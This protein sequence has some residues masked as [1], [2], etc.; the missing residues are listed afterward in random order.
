MQRTRDSRSGVSLLELAIVI[1]IIGMLVGGYV[2]AR[3]AIRQA[4]IRATLTQVETIHSAIKLFNQKFSG[5]PGDLYNATNFWGGTANGD[6]DGRIGSMNSATCAE[7]NAGEWFRAWQHLSSAGLIKGTFS[8]TAGGGGAAEAVIAANVPAA[9][10]RS[11]G[12]TLGVV[13]CPSGSTRF[14]PTQVAH[15]LRFG[16]FRAG[17]PTV[18]GAIGPDEAKQM[19]AK[20][21]DGLPGLGSV[22]GRIPGS[23][24]N[25][26]CTDNA[27]P[28]TAR[29]S[30]TLTTYECSLLFKVGAE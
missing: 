24:E 28:V 14:Y 25:P 3:S 1:I 5:L 15:Y 23:S 18:N 27:D 10:I 19:D 29:Y 2:I 8:G 20:I 6:G 16:A 9:D 30:A 22:R 13:D 11:A 7:G 12:F 4:E 17:S 26:L 21:D